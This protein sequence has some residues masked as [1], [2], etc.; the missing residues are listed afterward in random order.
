[1]PSLAWTPVEEAV[2]YLVVVSD[3]PTFATQLMS[4]VTPNTFY[5]VEQALEYSKTYYWRVRVT[6]DGPW[7]NGVFTTMAKPV[8]PT[9]PVEVKPPSPPEVVKVEVPT[10]I[11][12][13]IPSYLLWIV[14]VI[15]AVLIIALI[16]LIV[17]TRRI[18]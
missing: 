9:P 16:V 5:T 7:A 18:T 10:V 3:D 17:R 15:G 1:M 14:I 4:S 13:P 8:A 2:T 6:P 11:Q 12:Q